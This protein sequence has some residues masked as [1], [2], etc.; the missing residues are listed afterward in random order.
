MEDIL[1]FD[2]L[3]IWCVFSVKMLVY[4]VETM[5]NQTKWNNMGWFAFLNKMVD[6]ETRLIWFDF[7]F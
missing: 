3:P 4:L 5:N 6:L 2:S 7:N 1:N